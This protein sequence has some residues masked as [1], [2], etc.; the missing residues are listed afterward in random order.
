MANA[1]KF[2]PTKICS[3]CGRIARLQP[4]PDSEETPIPKGADASPIWFYFCTNRSCE[5]C[6]RAT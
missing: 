3:S 5:H 6:E 1:P 4:D 2:S